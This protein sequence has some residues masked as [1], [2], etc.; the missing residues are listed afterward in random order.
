MINSRYRFN[1]DLALHIKRSCAEISVSRCTV[2]SNLLYYKA[3]YNNI[4]N[5][6]STDGNGKQFNSNDASLHLLS[7]CDWSD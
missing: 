2:V 3:T 4:T 1:T 6:L 5:S 7:Y